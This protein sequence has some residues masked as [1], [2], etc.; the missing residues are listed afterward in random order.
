MSSVFVPDLRPDLDFV[1]DPDSFPDI[2]RTVVR[3]DHFAVFR[4][5]SVPDSRSHETPYR[6]PYGTPYGALYAESDAESER[7][8]N[9]RSVCAAYAVYAVYSAY[10][11]VRGS[12][13][14]RRIPRYVRTH[15]C[16]RLVCFSLL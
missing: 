5:F 7:Q 6:A 14:G 1:H 2:V 4:T 3:P 12:R 11:V 13:D 9:D 10:A 8:R 16:L 15:I